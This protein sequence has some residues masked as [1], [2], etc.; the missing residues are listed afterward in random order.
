MIIRIKLPGLHNVF[1]A[2]THQLICK[3]AKC[4]F[5]SFSKHR[6]YDIIW[7]KSSLGECHFLLTIS[8]CLLS[9]SQTKHLRNTTEL[10]LRYSAWTLGKRKRILFDEYLLWSAT[11][12]FKSQSSVWSMYNYFFL[13]DEKLGGLYDWFEPLIWDVTSVEWWDTFSP[14]SLKLQKHSV[15]VEC[16]TK[17]CNT[18]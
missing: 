5:V 10:T 17:Q 7:I 12:S 11:S 1:Y 9:S 16:H 13:T 2:E 4:F 6:T 14:R 18:W 3:H 8:V 15:T